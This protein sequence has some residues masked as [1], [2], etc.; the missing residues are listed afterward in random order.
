MNTKI[1]TFMFAFLFLVSFASAVEL[2]TIDPTTISV[3]TEVAHTAGSFEVSFDLE[4]VDFGGD[5]TLTL[6]PTISGIMTLQDAPVTITMAD[7]DITTPSTET[8][9]LTID[10]IEHQEGP[11]E[12]NILVTDD[13]IPQL[14]PFSVNITES[15]TITVSDAT[16]SGDTATITIENTGNVD[17]EDI[18]LTISRIE[19]TFSQNDFDLNAGASKT[20]T[21][22][23]NQD[24]LD[25]YDL[26]TY[27]IVTATAD[28]GTTNTGK[29]TSARSYCTLGNQPTFTNLDDEQLEISVEIDEFNVENGFGPEDNEWYLFDDVEVE[30]NVENKGDVK[31]KDIVLE[32]G[33]YSR[34]TGE[35]IFEEEESDFNLDEGDD[36]TIT[37]KFSLDADDFDEDAGDFVFVVK[38][39]SDRSDIGEENLCMELIE[40]VEVILDDE[41]AIVSPLNIDMPETVQCGELITVTAEVWNIGDSDLENVYVVVRNNALD[42]YERILIDDDL[43]ALDNEKIE[44]S[45]QVPKTAKEASYAID[46]IVYDEDDAVFETRDD[47]DKAITQVTLTIEGS[48]VAPKTLSVT[49]I[50][51]TDAIAGKEVT[52]TATLENIDSEEKTYTLVL[53]DYEEWAELISLSDE[54]ITLASG[55][56]TDI[57]II[58]KPNKDVV[59]DR[60]FTLQA[61]SDG[62][63]EETKLKL[64]VQP[65]Q[66]F[67]TGNVIGSLDLGN[68]TLVW[69][70]GLAIVILIILI[71]VVAVRLSG[72]HDEED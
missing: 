69:V 31:I 18:N 1:L 14:V 25:D 37:L 46:F 72:S 43:K 20:I 7:G 70:L 47:D 10:F 39:Y 2:N 32:W 35:F 9:T 63:V 62:Q 51:A 34:D 55:D 50:P 71:I 49:A 41:F 22:T 17:L 33:L 60:E 26:E 40:E 24:D 48:C 29:I 3:P 23:F 65:K 28:D 12:G 13:A 45:F 59:G 19:A 54:E 38:A 4:N 67:L 61:V 53:A 57:T 21:L 56:S 5:V 58:L 30:I 15:K 64:P 36:E 16:I 6:I 52:I 8:A 42:L 44:F 66:G 68:N 11:L 27:F